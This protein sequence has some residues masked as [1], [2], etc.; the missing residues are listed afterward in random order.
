MSGSNLRQA[1]PA[2][3]VPGVREA[4]EAAGAELRYLPQYSPDLNPIEMALSSLKAFLRKLAERTIPDLC[5]R[6]GWFVRSIG[7]R[8]CRNYLSHA[9]YA[10]K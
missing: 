2:H 5:Q 3:K 10:S 6:V 8:E 4:I 7:P 9:G 1:Q